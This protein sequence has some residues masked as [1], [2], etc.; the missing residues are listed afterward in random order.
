MKKTSPRKEVSGVLKDKVIHHL[1]H[2]LFS[3]MWYSVW[4]T[5]CS[6]K[7]RLFHTIGYYSVNALWGL[8]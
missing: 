4:N 3:Y 7:F 1:V 2:H 6:S 8:P 5:H